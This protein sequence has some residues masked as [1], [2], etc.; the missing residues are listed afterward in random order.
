MTITIDP[1]AGF[2][3]GV[4]LAISTAEKELSSTKNLL[5]LGEIV[6]NRKELDRLA[7]NGLKIIDYERFKNL[8]D[9][10]VLIRAHGEPPS[11]YQIAQQNNLQIIDATCPIVLKL[12]KKIRNG[13][14]EM[15]K[16]EGKIYIYGKKGHAEVIGLEAQ[17]NFEAVVI[18]NEDDISQIDFDKPIRLYSQTTKSK[19]GYRKLVENITEA[20]SAKTDDFI[21][22]D[23]TC[24]IVEQRS[25]KIVEFSRQ[26]DLIFFVSD[27]NSSNGKELFDLISKNNPNSYFISGIEDLEALIKIQFSTFASQLSI[28]ISGAT[29]TPF[30]LLED[31]KNCIING[32]AVLH[33]LI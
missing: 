32:F 12:Q 6:H 8:E 23:T 17:A 20:I 5:C 11:T 26:H 1:F 24:K 27:K 16:K 29:S 28:G 22:F 19:D 33:C 7:K 2:C 9:K 10:K 15:Q 4:V 30:W 18:E 3:F 13:Y 21:A 25:Q 31:V 14:E